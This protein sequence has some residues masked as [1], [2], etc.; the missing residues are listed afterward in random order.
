[1]KATLATARIE[2]LRF[3]RDRASMFS[4]VALPI[5]LILF[6]GLGFGESS[7]RL[8]LGLITDG[9]GPLGTKLITQLQE[10]PT[11]EVTAYTDRAALYRDI[12][13]GALG[14]GIG[15]PSDGSPVEVYVQ[16]ASAGAGIVM[17]TVNAAAAQVSTE[18][19]AVEVLSKTV[20]AT[21]ARDAVD[22]AASA[23]PPVSVSSRTLGML[24]E[25]EQNR[26]ASLRSSTGCWERWR[27]FRLASCE[28]SSA[29]WLLPTVWA[30]ICRG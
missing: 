23:T 24:N 25:M 3:F 1:M 20:S 22:A 13:L 7:S 6:I 16:Q 2:W 21:R 5:M 26:F 8:P 10:S 4:T 30:C 29:P 11:L 18:A 9:P 12:R 19:V 14:G 17:S 28:S 27:S 15:I